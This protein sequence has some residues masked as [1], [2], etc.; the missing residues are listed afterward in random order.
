M[1]EEKRTE[2]QIQLS[3]ESKNSQSSGQRESSLNYNKEA[4]Q[5][6]SG[7]GNRKQGEEV[8]DSIR[9]IHQ[10]IKTEIA[11][12]STKRTAKS[13]VMQIIQAEEIIQ[14]IKRTKEI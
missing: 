9:I 12:V 4:K 11:K 5:Q 2:A 8:G 1:G 10:T 6:F 14:G 3:K 13:I 7:N